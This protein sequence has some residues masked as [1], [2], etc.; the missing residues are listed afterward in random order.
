MY[1]TVPRMVPVT[2]TSA[3]QPGAHPGGAGRDWP[4]VGDVLPVADRAIPKSMMMAWSADQHD[5]GGLEIAVHDAGFVRRHEPGHDV[6]DDATAPRAPAA[7]PSRFEHGREIRALEVR[8]RDVLD[9]V[10]LAEIV[11]ADDVLVRDLAGEDQLLLEP[12]LHLPRRIRVAR[13]LGADDF[14]RDPLPELRVPHL[15]HRAH[16]AN[17]Q[18]FDDVIAGAERLAR[19]ASG[20]W[21]RGA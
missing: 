17:A 8:H 11:N 18:H 3:G 5:V 19:R 10:D 4:L 14:E 9:A 21:W 2:V 1:L 7:C 20:P 12:A 16:P 6:P 13:R 15:V